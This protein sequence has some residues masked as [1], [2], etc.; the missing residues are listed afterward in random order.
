MLKALTACLNVNV[1]TNLQLTFT[2]FACLCVSI[3]HLR[4]YFQGG[5]Q[6]SCFRL[7]CVRPPAAAW[8][9]P[10]RQSLLQLHRKRLLSQHIPDRHDQLGYTWLVLPGAVTQS[11]C[12]SP[13]VLSKSLHGC[14]SGQLYLSQWMHVQSLIPQACTEMVMPMC[15]NGVQDMFEL[16]EWNFQAYSDGCYTMFGV[17]PRVDWAATVYGGKDI[18]SHSNIIFRWTK[19]NTCQTGRRSPVVP[20]FVLCNESNLSA[21]FDWFLLMHIN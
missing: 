14:V 4:C 13:V 2:C 19:N 18:A 3:I 6:V 17:R 11:T 20:G 8:D 5:V 9:L 21:D 7:R 1:I 12:I 15:T 16:E 10:S